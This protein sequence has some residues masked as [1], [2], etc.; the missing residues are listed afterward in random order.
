MADVAKWVMAE[1]LFLE[2]DCVTRTK[3]CI[4]SC[5]GVVVWRTDVLSAVEIRLAGWN[6]YGSC[7]LNQILSALTRPIVVS[8]ML[9]RAH[10]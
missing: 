4:D 6:D 3:K 1:E 5:E 2:I 7:W 8:E 10:C 9:V